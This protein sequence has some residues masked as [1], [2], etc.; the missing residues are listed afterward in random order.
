MNGYT[1][2]EMRIAPNILIGIC[3]LGVSFLIYILSSSSLGKRS[4]CHAV[5]FTNLLVPNPTEKGL[6]HVG[7]ASTM[8][9][10]NATTPRRKNSSSGNIRDV[11]GLEL[12]CKPILPG[13]V[14]L[15]VMTAKQ[16][17]FFLQWQALE[18]AFCVWLACLACM[19]GPCLLAWYTVYQERT[20]CCGD[21][22]CWLRWWHEQL[23]GAG[24]I[25]T[26]SPPPNMMLLLIASASVWF[27]WR[28]VIHATRMPEGVFRFSPF[29]YI[30]GWIAIF[31]TMF[32][33][34][35]T[36]DTTIQFLGIPLTAALE[37]WSARVT[38]WISLTGF[39]S[40]EN[41]TAREQ[42]LENIFQVTK[43]LFS[44]VTG[45][46]AFAVA[47]P[48]R[49]TMLIYFQFLC[50]DEVVILSKSKGSLMGWLKRKQ[51]QYT[52]L[53]VAFLPFLC[54]GTYLVPATS[55]QLIPPR[56]VRAILAWLFIWSMATV[57]RTLLQMYLLQA[58]SAADRIFDRT[59]R[60]SAEEVL[61]Q[62]QN[63]TGRLVSTGG[64][65]LVYPAFVLLI[66]AVGQG[67]G[68]KPS[69]LSATNTITSGIYPFAFHQSLW[70]EQEMSDYRE[71]EE[72]QAKASAQR[73]LEDTSIL[74]EL[75]TSSANIGLCHENTTFE[76]L[77][78]EE[79]IDVIGKQSS[80][81]L[82]EFSSPTYRISCASQLF[83]TSGVINTTFVRVL[84][85]LQ[86]LAKKALMDNESAIDQDQAQPNVKHN[87]STAM[88]SS[89]GEEVRRDFRNIVQA[90]A[91]H[92]LFTSTIIL[93]VLDF[94]GFGLASIWILFFLYYAMVSWPG[95]RTRRRYGIRLKGE[96][97]RVVAIQK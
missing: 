79:R 1:N 27:W 90:M 25:F 9:T 56:T 6:K 89:D 81:A 19:I 29:S 39:Y 49:E 46:V 20:L 54:F 72:F 35:A 16:K 97:C 14:P 33:L 15:S 62:F 60:P 5:L 84:R 95:R 48:M 44:F 21:V 34:W 11:S 45:T 10:D 50:G 17:Q 77:P 53:C 18:G 69:A 88:A 2:D 57:L 26:S 85:K 58:L 30:N 87:K 3:A 24:V 38:L 94:L 66:L 61:F 65:L 74:A 73:F 67:A 76:F 83:A 92:P 43:L 12:T 71:W 78:I 75:S 40:P 55:F 68:E 22:Q 31:S 91:F 64:Q 7:N 51:L 13:A 59:K 41:E 36:S 86:G 4:I 32:I 8:T 82:G 37:E 80:R 47:D 63:R 42:V 93:P 28:L 70:T 96:F 23:G 52:M